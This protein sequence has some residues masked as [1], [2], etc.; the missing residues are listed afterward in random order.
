MQPAFAHFTDHTLWRLQLE[1]RLDC[2]TRRSLSLRTNAMGYSISV[3]KSRNASNI[4]RPSSPQGPTFQDSYRRSFATESQPTNRT[5]YTPLCLSSSWWC[6]GGRRSWGSRCGWGWSRR[7]VLL[8]LLRA[9]GVV[10][11]RPGGRGHTSSWL[12]VGYLRHVEFRLRRSWRL[13][14]RCIDRLGLGLLWDLGRGGL[15]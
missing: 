5:I 1:K 11:E 6:R 4:A 9:E 10:V 3:M 15:S 13:S 12:R 8:L 2:Y 7:D 14:S